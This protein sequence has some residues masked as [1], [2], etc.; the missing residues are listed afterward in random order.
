MKINQNLKN[1]CA[2]IVFCRNILCL[3]ISY[4]MLPGE[5]RK[6][7][8]WKFY[9]FCPLTVPTNLHMVICIVSYTLKSYNCMICIVFYDCNFCISYHG[10]IMK[11]IC[12]QSNA[13]LKSIYSFLYGSYSVNCMLCIAI[14]CIMKII[15]TSLT[16][17]E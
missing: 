14:H 1:G 7:Q 16:N 12:I 9:K 3:T 8:M 5:I 2:S 4:Y 6:N 17:W 11:W 10:W 13:F 15:L